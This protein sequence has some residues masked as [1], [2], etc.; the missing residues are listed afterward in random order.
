MKTKHPIGTRKKHYQDKKR[1]NID[2]NVVT[3]PTKCRRLNSNNSSE[4][5][6]QGIGNRTPCSKNIVN[7]MNQ[8]LLEMNAE[9]GPIVTSV[10]LLSKAIEILQRVHGNRHAVRQ[11]VVNLMNQHVAAEADYAP[12]LAPFGT[13]PVLYDKD[14]FKR[15]PFNTAIPVPLETGRTNM[16]RA[17]KRLLDALDTCLQHQMFVLHKVI[18]TGNK[19]G[20]G[21]GLGL[22]DSRMTDER[23]MRKMVICIDNL[24]HTQQVLGGKI[25]DC[26]G[27]QKTAFLLISPTAPKEDASVELHEQHDKW[28]HII[29]NLL[30]LSRGARA[31]MKEMSFYWR[32]MM[33]NLMEKNTPLMHETQSVLHCQR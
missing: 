33:G 25:N 21:L 14:I 31:R 18:T 1:V 11:S 7:D 3:P 30:S 5:A 16:K 32:D 9:S 8:L 27:F 29:G 10:W 19:A 15:H 26:I 13:L 23:A 22:L 20:I 2:E 12:A 6:L 28:L 24:L 17:Q 4:V